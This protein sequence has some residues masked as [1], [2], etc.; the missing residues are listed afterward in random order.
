MPANPPDNIFDFKGF[1]QPLTEAEMDTMNLEFVSGPRWRL[2]AGKFGQDIPGL[3]I[4]KQECSA[5]AFTMD[6]I[7]YSTGDETLTTINLL[8]WDEEENGPS[9]LSTSKGW[10]DVTKN[11]FVEIARHVN[12]I[13]ISTNGSPMTDDLDLTIYIKG[14]KKPVA[15]KSAKLVVEYV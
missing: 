1:S 11:G 5:P 14:A 6:N 7:K 4:P 13:P 8:D 10:V 3:D 9:P 15:I 12:G 2:K